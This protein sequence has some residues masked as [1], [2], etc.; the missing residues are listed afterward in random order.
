[1]LNRVLPGLCLLAALSWPGTAHAQTPYT[2]S[3]VA[4]DPATTTGKGGAAGVTGGEDQVRG[5]SPANSWLGAQLGY[6]F[7]ANS[8]ELGDN[9]LVSASVI[10]EIPLAARKLKLPVISNFSDLVANP[11]TADEGDNS[12]DKLKELLL[13]SSGVRAGLYPYR[14]IESVGGEDFTLVV[15]GEASWKLNGFKQQDSDDVNYLNQFRLGAGFE[16]AIGLAEG[17]HKPL[18]LSVTPVLTAFGEKEY[19]K[20]FNQPKSRLTTVEIVA[21]LPTS[22]RTGVLFE[23][24]R[25]DVNSFRAGVIVAGER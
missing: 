25:G 1:M 23:F 4:K 2:T 24:V 15:H 14:V 18:T 19:E 21:V 17:G 6:K 12:D 10:Y 16:V 7:G 22:A 3:R 13:A 9:L 11:S 8:K 20:I 5:A